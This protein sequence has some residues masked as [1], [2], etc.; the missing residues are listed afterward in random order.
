MRYTNYNSITYTAN[1]K[2]YEVYLV[3]KNKVNNIS[4][5]NKPIIVN[6]L[7]IVNNNQS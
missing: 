3:I 1:S 4:S 7:I 6:E 2:L 5:T